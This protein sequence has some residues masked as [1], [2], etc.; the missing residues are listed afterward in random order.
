MLSLAT[1]VIFESGRFMTWQAMYQMWIGLL[2]WI[3]NIISIE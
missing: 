3:S 1:E 2:T